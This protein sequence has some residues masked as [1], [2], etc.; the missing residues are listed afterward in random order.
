MAVAVRTVGEATHSSWSLLYSLLVPTEISSLH[1]QAPTSSILLFSPLT[2]PGPSPA[3]QL[4]M[5]PQGPLEKARPL[6]T[7]I[8]QPLRATSSEKVLVGPVWSPV[9]P[10][11]QHGPT[12][13]VVLNE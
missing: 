11:T 9:C 7:Y 5:A 1:R 8:L 2:Y 10:Y 12:T 6:P 13:Q 4:A 3:P